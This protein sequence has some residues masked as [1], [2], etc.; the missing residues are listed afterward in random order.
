MAMA[1]MSSLPMSSLPLSSLP[2]SSMA[3]PGFQPAVEPTQL[4]QILMLRLQ[5]QMAANVNLM[6]QGQTQGQM[7]GL[8]PMLNPML[9]PSVAVVTPVET[10]AQRRNR[11]RSRR[12]KTAKAQDDDKDQEERRIDPSDKRRKTKEEFLM[13]HAVGADFSQGEELWEAALSRNTTP[14]RS[15]RPAVLVPIPATKGVR[16]AEVLESTVPQWDGPT[17]SI[18]K[19]R[20]RV[21]A[22]V[23]G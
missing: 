4:A 17:L 8:N 7:Q 3:Q 23:T 9:K 20:S 19:V 22:D 10:Q 1:M 5:M 2:M 21:P 14:R 13:D 18:L 16:F 6:Q 15:P 11:S 12:R